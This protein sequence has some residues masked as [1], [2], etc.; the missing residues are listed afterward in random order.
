MMDQVKF[1]VRSAFGGFL[2]MGLLA[3]SF[4]AAIIL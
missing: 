1:W 2:F 4:L 3:A